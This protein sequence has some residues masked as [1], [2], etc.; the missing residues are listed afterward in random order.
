[1]LKAEFFSPVNDLSVDWAFTSQPDSLASVTGVYSLKNGFPDVEGARVAIVGVP[2]YR[3]SVLNRH[4]GN[5]TALIREKLYRL[6]KHG[7]GNLRIIDLGDL[8]PGH[9]IEDT[10]FALTEILTELMSRRVVPVI[11]GGS[12]DLTLAH[13]NAYKP[14][15]NLINIAAVDSTFDLGTPDE[16]INSF[17]WLGKIILQQPNFLFNFSN[18]GYQSYFTGNASIEMMSKLFFDTYRLGE[19]RQDMKEIEPVFRTADLLSFDLS[20]IRQS[21]APGTT[22]PSPHGFTGEEACQM[23]MY[24]GMND[25]LTGVGIYEYNAETDREGQTAHLAAHMIW[26]F[27]EGLNNRKADFPEKNRESFYIY[28]V[29]GSV[30]SSEILFL[31]HKI[32][33]RWW[34]EMPLHDHSR[35][36]F[37]NRFRFLPCSAND[38][39]LACENEIPGRYWQAV[40]KL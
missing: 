32:T 31:K 6:K 7:D 37:I 10:F 15:G 39:R 14:L 16:E 23:M 13:Y 35:G 1:M 30:I 22:H 20:S 12:Q 40:R 8:M 17:N 36:N 5:G 21:D 3:G 4:F 38:Y 18:I 26:Y 19:V 28:R 34:M 9:T 11:I 33:G 29:T 27:L 25:H 24:A 2:E